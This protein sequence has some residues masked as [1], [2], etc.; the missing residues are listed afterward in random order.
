[1]VVTSLKP[2]SV[3]ALRPF[4]IAGRDTNAVGQSHLPKDSQLSM[5]YIRMRGPPLPA[6]LHCGCRGTCP[7]QWTT[8]ICRFRPGRAVR[9][10]ELRLSRVPMDYVYVRE[11]PLSRLKKTWNAQNRCNGLH[12]YALLSVDAPPPGLCNEPMDY[13][14]MH[15][16]RVGSRASPALPSMD[17]VYMLARFAVEP[18]KSL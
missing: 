12:S 8:F 15:I 6:S 17:Y 7:G 16:R 5:D 3:K 11:R 10:L 1:M 4:I 9:K 14:H 2:L 13:V 18:S